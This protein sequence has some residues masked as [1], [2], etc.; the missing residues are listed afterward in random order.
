MLSSNQ[1]QE[2][3]A[4]RAVNKFAH[5]VKPS[6]PTI[7]KKEQSYGYIQVGSDLRPQPQP[8][9]IYSGIGQDTVGPAAYNSHHQ[10][11]N[12]RKNV[13][14]SLRST[15]KREV[16]EVN[17]PH[18]S[19]PGPGHYYEDPVAATIGG[20]SGSEAAAT[21]AGKGGGLRGRKKHSKHERQSAVFA[22]KVPILPDTKPRTQYDSELAMEINAKESRLRYQ[23]ERQKT[24]I[25]KAKIEAFGS[26]TG[27][28]ELSS[29][30]SAPFSNP[31]FTMTPGPG[32]Y[33]DRTH[34]GLRGPKKH[35]IPASSNREESMGFSSATERYCLSKPKKPAAPGPGAYKSETP[36]SL[37]HTVK[38]KSTIGRNGIFGST[39]ER[40]VWEQLTRL[41]AAD[42]FTP[43]PGAYEKPVETHAGHF[44]HAANSA[45]FKSN[46]LRFSKQTNP[47]APPRV[48][49]VGDHVAPAVG[50]YD[51]PA[52]L[53]V[54]TSGSSPGKPGCTP[55]PTSARGGAAF[56]SKCERAVFDTKDVRDLP[57]PGAYAG[58]EDNAGMGTGSL[59]GM[60][61][62][63]VKQA[64][65]RFNEIRSS[66]G[67]EERFRVKPTV[68]ESV[69]PG[70][71]S[72]PGTV[73]SK[74]FN[75]TMKASSAQV[76]PQ[77]YRQC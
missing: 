16:W 36:R 47:H 61:S 33:S 77:R 70:A 38:S 14:P 9:I 40:H 30:L 4:G 24:N 2:A 21:A 67:N 31:S 59:S 27:R 20:P 65:T 44:P 69:G 63:T 64:T 60:S 75:V 41:E 68:P 74:S 28:V 23:L 52:S 73:G 55:P 39:S 7:P 71:Y 45:A 58:D 54:G 17:T 1:M 49:C 34:S 56:L 26:T 53:G 32:M 43:G 37:D 5:F 72:I 8:A 48:H 15:V 51:I 76:I 57:G 12:E 11:W 46:S 42:D 13:A 22:S 6:A 62:S 35:R 50:Q 25:M 19:V 18:S 10:I 3:E 29:Q 66:I